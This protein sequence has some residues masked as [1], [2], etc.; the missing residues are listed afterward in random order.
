MGIGVSAVFVPYAKVKCTHLNLDYRPLFRDLL[1]YSMSIAMMLIF[2]A[3]STPA[4]V[5]WWESL[6]LVLGYCL[7]IYVMTINEKLMDWMEKKFGPPQGTNKVAN[8]GQSDTDT[9]A[10]NGSNTASGSSSGSGK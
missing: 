10:L 7:Y 8:A 5:D 1:F 6:L 2:F 4:V 9:T 3:V